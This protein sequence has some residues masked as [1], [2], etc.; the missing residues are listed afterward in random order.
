MINADLERIAEKSQRNQLFVNPSKSKALLIK[1]RRRTAPPNPLPPVKLDR[2][3]IEW[4][5]SAKNLGFIHQSD[6]QW[7]SLIS[8]QCGKIYAS[9]RSLY[10]CAS[11]APIDT[12][13]KLLKA[14]ILPHFMFGDSL[15]IN[16]RSSD[17]VNQ[18]VPPF[19]DCDE[20]PPA[21][22]WEKWREH[23]EAY[24]DWTNV[25]DHDEKFKCLMLFGGSDIR[26]IVSKVQI[27]DSHPLNNR[28]RTALQLLD[29]YFIPRVSKTYERQTFRQMV[30]EANEKLDEFAIRLKKQATNCSFENQ[31]DSMIADQ[32]IST[33]KDE[34][35]K[36]K[37]LEKDHTLEEVL[38][39]GRTHESV[40]FQLN[41]WENGITNRIAV[42]TVQTDPVTVM[43]ARRV[44]KTWDKTNQKETHPQKKKRFVREV[45]GDDANKKTE[46]QIFDLFHLGSK[47]RFISVTIGGVL[48]KLIINTGADEDILSE[49]DWK[50][51]KS[52][53]F[54]AYSVK[55]GSN[56]VFN[57]YGSKSSL[58]VLGEINTDIAFKG[59]SVETTLYVIQGGKCSLLSGDTAIKLDIIKFLNLVKSDPF[60]CITGIEANIKINKNIPPVRQS[61]RRIPFPS[62][63]LTLMKLKELEKQDII[64]RVTE[65]S[66]WVSPMLV[67]RKSANEVRIIVDL[68]EANKAVVR[69]VHPLP[70]LEQMTKKICTNKIFTKLDIKQAF[71]QVVL[72]EE[73]RY[74][75]TFISPIGLMRYKRLMFGLSAAP[76]LFQKVMETIFAYLSWLIIFIDDI[77]I[78]ANNE[79]ELANRVN[80]VRKRLRKHNILIN[81]CKVEEAVRE[82]DFLGYHISKQG[83]SVAQEKLDTIKKL[84]PPKS[85][86]EVRS[87]LG[88]INFVHRYIPDMA[89]I[90]YPLNLLTRK[91]TKFNWDTN[92]QQ[93]F[94]K[95]KHILL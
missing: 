40:Q 3:T 19:I 34:K 52:T 81:D 67:K 46:S 77:L 43:K 13:L 94:E 72:K 84:N 25:V 8:Q 42:N 68:H 33:T 73:C 2:Q 69:E 87:F 71:H 63:D 44:E 1:G 27:D 12:S 53:G 28:Y 90:T 26:K 58:K 21:V 4:V 48:L 74:I 65:A 78:P 47:K 35:L 85:M 54:E 86:E 15:L 31:T 57:A 37:C 80:L 64:E 16:A 30:P 9:L 45:S 60:P 18:I 7:D 70:T 29:E 32:I 17:M 91:G 49:S 20:G 55:K 66:E 79:Q 11:F 22:R 59:K 89:T 93:A 24:L 92:H 41:A 82:I 83:I 56:K 50:M 5:D 61:L 76:E 23:F 10:C 36:R 38:T 95:I 39:M 88:L 75:T 51:L 62:K 6:L 14:L